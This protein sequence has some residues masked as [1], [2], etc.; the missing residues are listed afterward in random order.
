MGGRAWPRAVR[1]RSLP[2][3]GDHCAAGP[4]DWSPLHPTSHHVRLS[5]ASHRTHI[6]CERAVLQ[7]AA[8]SLENVNL[9]WI[10]SKCG[11][12]SE[13][14]FSQTE[15]YVTEWKVFVSEA[16]CEDTFLWRSLSLWRNFIGINRERNTTL[17]CAWV[18]AKT[19]RRGEKRYH[20]WSV[21]VSRYAEKKNLS[22]VWI[23]EFFFTLTRIY[24]L[25][26]SATTI[27]S[28]LKFTHRWDSPKLVHFTSFLSQHMWVPCLW[29]KRPIGITFETHGTR[30]PIWKDKTFN[31]ES[32]KKGYKQGLERNVNGQIA[33]GC[34]CTFWR[35][36]I[37]SCDRERVDLIIHRQT[38]LPS[39]T[40]TIASTVQVSGS[41]LFVFFLPLKTV[42][43][44]GRSAR[45][46]YHFLPR[47]LGVWP[48]PPWWQSARPNA[49]P[50]FVL[51]AV[52]SFS[53]HCI[54]ELEAGKKTDQCGKKH[55]TLAM[56]VINISLEAKTLSLFSA[57]I[58]L[59]FSLF[60]N[61]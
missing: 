10:S 21:F 17:L 44:S 18:F 58:L 9:H 22:R 16:A 51:H 20:L 11:E 61:S 23:R 45:Y 27:H 13:K 56:A 60:S 15:L 54:Q 53:C 29:T 41:L 50:S 26:K 37:H 31:I 12:T 48:E 47:L 33:T 59:S 35:H 39:D 2:A 57:T 28:L 5:T 3:D 55:D 30:T 24:G 42:L 49:D 32:T 38:I 46:T 14:N 34:T 52:N 6:V 36:W 4:I 1:R 8:K 25:L 19:K 43:P 40:S 7:S